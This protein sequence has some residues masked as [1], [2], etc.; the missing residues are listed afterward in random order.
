MRYI[1]S[2]SF[3]LLLWLV[4]FPVFM[5]VGF[6]INSVFYPAFAEWFPALV[7]RY[8]F[9]L[10]REEYD[11]LYGTLEL[12]TGVLT[13]GLISYIS[14]RYD[15]ERM[16][17]MIRKTDGMYSIREG[18]NIYYPRYFLND[19][20]LSCTVPLP[21]FLIDALLLPTLT[22]LPEGVNS[23]LSFVFLPSRAFSAGF[24]VIGGCMLTAFFFFVF[25]ILSG[26]RAIDVYRALWL[27]EIEYMG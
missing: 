21:L 22:F 11:A 15:N 13:V 14:V 10:E 1:K 5:F 9:V 16:E 27:S 2:F 6:L 25:R 3:G 20:A 8:N 26:V 12:F 4:S 19:I 23:L 24:G 17:Y 18:C 7:P